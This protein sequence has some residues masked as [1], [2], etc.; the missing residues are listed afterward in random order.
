MQTTTLAS[1]AII[2]AAT[3]SAAADEFVVQINGDVFSNQITSGLLGNVN[4]GESVSYAF[5]VD[6]DNFVNGAFPT[7]GYEIDLT[8]FN[9]NF[10]GGTSI[11]VSPAFAGPAYFVLR[12]NDPV[13]DGFF[14]SQ[15]LDLPTG[16]PL[17]QIGAFGNFGAAFSVG[18]TGDTLDSLDIADAL[19][20]Y[21]FTG[22]TNFG[23]GVDDGPFEGVLGIDFSSMTITI[24]P[25]PSS[26]A[27][28]S[29]AGLAAARRRR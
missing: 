7:R 12:N 27:M 8:T 29:L 5:T 19:G 14:L 2:A 28:L 25:A 20:T 26:M 1:I 23:M 24:I 18:Y 16:I 6:S 9:L 3:A 17:D 13:V 4:A 10:S 21:D 11:G 22:L 15:G